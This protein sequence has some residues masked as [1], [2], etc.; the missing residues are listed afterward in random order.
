V[1]KGGKS[2]TLAY[3]I[4]RRTT[5]TTSAVLFDTPIVFRSHGTTPGC[6]GFTGPDHTHLGTR[7][8]AAFVVMAHTTAIFSAPGVTALLDESPRGRL[9][10]TTDRSSS[11]DQRCS[12]CSQGDSAWA[13]LSW[14]YALGTR[15]GL[16]RSVDTPLALTG[17]QQAAS[18][19]FCGGVDATRDS[20]TIAHRAA[21]ATR[22]NIPPRKRHGRST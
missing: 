6:D 9:A 10:S 2:S 19:F 18:G 12:I 5:H 1:G 17:D 4:K 14:R 3:F 15:G 16:R 13:A 21:G 8:S 11:D 20:I 7:A 22:L